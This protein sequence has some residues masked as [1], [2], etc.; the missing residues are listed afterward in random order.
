MYQKRGIRVYLPVFSDRMLERLVYPLSWERSADSMSF[1]EW[2]LTARAKFTECLLT[3]PPAAPYEP[4]VV[5]EE[6]R[7]G[8]TA[9]RI[10]FNLSADSRVLAYLLVPD[11]AG[12]FPTVHLLHDHG[13]RFDIGKEKV[14][15]PFDEPQERIESAHEWVDYCYGGRWIGDELARRGYA[16]FASDAL[17]WSDRGGVGYEQMGALCANMM[18]LG[19][20]MAGTIAH[21]DLRANEFLASM[22]EVDQSRIAAMGLSFGSYRTWQLSAL[23]DQVA[24]GVAICWLSTIAGQMQPGVNMT[25]GAYPMVHPNLHNSLDIP[26]VASI[27][28]PKPMLS[29]HGLQDGLFGTDSVR[30]A[31]AKMRAVWESQGVGDRLET[32]MWDV[33]HEFNVDMQAAAFSWLDEQMDVPSTGATEAQ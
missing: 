26:D 10:V 32:R 23:T 7:N 25:T 2:R 15:R 3:P 27:A 9:R 5:G 16:C 30:A 12:P 21:E 6:R 31:H 19:S 13:A 1:D 11:G 24:A 18:L 20:S 17:F 8:Y 33:P 14:I 22:P 29:Y 28:C 4:V